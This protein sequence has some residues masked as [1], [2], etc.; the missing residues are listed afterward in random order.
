MNNETIKSL[1]GKLRN[2]PAQAGKSATVRELVDSSLA[3]IEEQKDINAVVS[4]YSKDFLDT[5]IKKAEEMFANNQA[6]ELTGIPI[7]IKDNILV[8]GEIASAGSKILEN[9]KATYDA[10]VI[11]KLKEAGAILIGRANMDEFA[12]GSSTENSFYGV[13]KNPHDTSRVAGGSSGGSAAVVSYGGVTVSLGTDTGGSIRQPASFCGVVG[14]KTT[15]GMV[16]RF[17]AVAMGSSLDQIGPFAN[18]VDDIETVF[19]IITGVD[20]LDSTSLPENLRGK[21]NNL[22]KKIGV[23]FSFVNRDGIDK[24][25]LENFNVSLEKMK[26]AGYEVV[27][28]DMEHLEKALA[29]YYIL[30]P[31]EVSSNLARYDGIRYGLSVAGETSIESY[32]NSRTEGF[33][34]EVRRRILLGTYVLSSGYYDSYYNKA[35]MVR[36]M[37]K[38]EFA[39]VFEKVDVIATPTSPVPAFLIGEKAKDPLAMYLADIFTVPVNIVGVPAIS[40]PSGKTKAGLPLGLQFIAPHYE[41]NTLFT[42]SRDFE[43]L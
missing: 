41:E 8:K 33:G 43:R 21:K 42:V 30:M 37:L 34:K 15:Y 40:I 26:S 20:T 39:K 35:N 36:E 9:Y 6:T 17:G 10:T 1:G 11:K 12:M 5:Q 23:P 3:K 32:F 4:I 18:N 22:K 2:L 14:L 25:V 16:S 13:T 24:E 19:N 31:A 28:I 27:D 38:K 29:V 7:I